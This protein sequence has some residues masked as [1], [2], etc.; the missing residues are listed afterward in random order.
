MNIKV[1]DIFWNEENAIYYVLYVSDIEVQYTLIYKS[2]IS[3]NFVQK[4]IFENT[5]VEKRYTFQST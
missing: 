4:D 3:R 2:N 1:G 5:M